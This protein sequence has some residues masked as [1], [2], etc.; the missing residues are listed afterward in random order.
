MIILNNISIQER[1]VFQELLQRIQDCLHKVNPFIQ[2]FKQ[3][4]EIP[5]EDIA[6]GVIVI[7]AKAPTGEHA[8]R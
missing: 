5:D 1:T 4:M 6:N 8:R 2:D 3:I 7:S